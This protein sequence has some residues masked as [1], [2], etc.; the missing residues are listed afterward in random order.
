MKL[1]RLRTI[2]LTPFVLFAVFYLFGVAA[3]LLD[4]RRVEPLSNPGSGSVDT[5]AIF[6]ASGT[7]GDGIDTVTTQAGGSEGG[8]ACTVGGR[9]GSDGG[10][11]ALAIVL[12][13]RRR[14]FAATRQSLRSIEPSR[15][16]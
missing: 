10:W 13:W 7:A 14:R 6:G 12:L 4:D 3:N 11:L 5:I 2:L 16:E 9:S 15:S 8:C 1:P